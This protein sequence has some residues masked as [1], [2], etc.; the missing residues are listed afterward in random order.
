MDEILKKL[1]GLK[2][3]GLKPPFGEKAAKY[4]E[5]AKRA[6]GTNLKAIYVYGSSLTGD[7]NP[8]KSNVNLLF[9]ME[10]IDPP[11]LRKM[12]GLKKHKRLVPMFL[13]QEHIESSADVFP[14]EYLEI[15]ENNLLLYGEDIFKG[16]AINPSNIRLQCEQQVKGGLIRLYQVYLETGGK[17]RTARRVMAGWLRNLMPVLRNLLRL[18]GIEPPVSKRAIITQVSRKFGLKEELLLDIL[19]GGKTGDEREMFEN[20]I[21]LVEKLGEEVDGLKL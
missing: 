16:L 6:L 11:D 8:A 18:K 10:K 21:E 4:C 7:F 9:I 20:F 1:G 12:F 17:K 5:E 19:D 13:T 3:P 15:K 2:P 14:V